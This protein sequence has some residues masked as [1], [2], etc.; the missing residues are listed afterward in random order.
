MKR[1]LGSF[2]SIAAC[3]ALLLGLVAAPQPAKAAASGSFAVSGTARFERFPCKMPPPNTQPCK[4]TLTGSIVSSV[5][6]QDAS[7]NPF[8]LVLNTRV[9]TG[10]NNGGPE[11]S[12]SYMND[13]GGATPQCSQSFGAGTVNFDTSTRLNEA[14]GSYHNSTIPSSIIGARG[15]VAYRWRSVGTVMAFTIIGAE[16]D[17]NVFGLGWKRLM[18]APTTTLGASGAGFFAPTTTSPQPLLDC[19]TSAEGFTPVNA[20]IGWE[21]GLAGN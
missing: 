12:F 9:G 11:S 3:M 1:R 19:A 18:S 16:I 10:L 2:V 14:F 8:E 4:A 13:L 5:S 6:G 21:F 15:S 7:G 17:A 20:T